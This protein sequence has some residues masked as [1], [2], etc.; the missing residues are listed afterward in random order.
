MKDG[1]GVRILFRF[2]GGVPLCIQRRIRA[3]FQ[4]RV[5]DMVLKMT[6]RRR[7]VAPLPLSEEAPPLRIQ[8]LRRGRSPASLRFGGKP[9][10]VCRRRVCI[11]P[12]R[13][14]K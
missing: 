1:V 8:I 11:H 13:N 10:L 4:K 9:L 6:L 5:R 7:W 2:C 3:K 12:K 14:L